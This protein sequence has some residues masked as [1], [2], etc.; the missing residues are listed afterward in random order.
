MAGGSDFY[1]ERSK[2]RV[3]ILLILKEIQDHMSGLCL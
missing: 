2:V 3:Q 1:T